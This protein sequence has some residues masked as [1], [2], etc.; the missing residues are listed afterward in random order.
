MLVVGPTAI[1]TAIPS[2]NKPK[3]CVPCVTEMA[4]SLSQR[5]RPFTIAAN[6]RKYT[7]EN[8]LPIFLSFPFEL[9]VILVER[10]IIALKHGH[11]SYLPFVV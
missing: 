5:C 7:N 4:C 11:S 9:H 2:N 8:M 6:A 10:G 1:Q 3:I